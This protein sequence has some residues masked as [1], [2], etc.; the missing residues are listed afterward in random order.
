MVGMIFIILCLVGLT[1]FLYFRHNKEIPILILA[2]AVTGFMFILDVIG[3][4]LGNWSVEL[5]LIGTIIANVV[6]RVAKR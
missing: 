4:L 5:I 6:V 2:L 1:I 3:M